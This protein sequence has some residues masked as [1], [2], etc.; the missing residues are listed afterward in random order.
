M[1][2]C[3]KVGVGDY[4]P[5]VLVTLRALSM[6]IHGGHT[7][8]GDAPQ[9]PQH[10]GEAAGEHAH[11]HGRGQVHHG[12]GVARG[13]TGGGPCAAWSEV[14]RVVRGGTGGGPSAAW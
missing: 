7:G 11:R 3:E 2:A 6:V 8:H 5:A 1:G 10:E 12:E 9:D 4:Y 14:V 13:G